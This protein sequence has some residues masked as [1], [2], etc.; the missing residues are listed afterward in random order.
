MFQKVIKGPFCEK[1]DFWVSFPARQILWVSP[2]CQL[3]T[4]WDGSQSLRDVIWQVGNVTYKVNLLIHTYVKLKHWP[5]SF[6]TMFCWEALWNYGM[7]Q[8]M[9]NWPH[10]GSDMALT[11]WGTD[12]SP[13]RG[14]LWCLAPGLW[15]WILWD[16]C[17]G[18][19]RL[20]GSDLFWQGC[21]TGLG[22]GNPDS[23]EVSTISSLSHSLTIP[24]QFLWCGRAPCPTGWATTIEQ[25]CWTSEVAKVR[26]HLKVHHCHSNN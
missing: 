6:Y 7:Y 25:M 24:E 12:T 11:S 13:L 5:S 1:A 8:S 22:S 10:H 4:L 21:S 18:W 9:S 17:S 15:C 2:T 20:F 19:G 3:R 14:V 16:F 26:C 23:L